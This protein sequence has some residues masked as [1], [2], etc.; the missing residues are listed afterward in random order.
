MNRH[1]KLHET[2]KTLTLTEKDRMSAGLARALE[3]I[4]QHILVQLL[5]VVCMVKQRG[6]QMF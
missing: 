1:M 3:L 4:A 2:R 6:L 5:F